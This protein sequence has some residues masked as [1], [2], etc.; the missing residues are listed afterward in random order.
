[1]GAGCVCD[2][3]ISNY[4]LKSNDNVICL[5]NGHNYYQQKSNKRMSNKK[6]HVLYN[7]LESNK[8][9]KEIK[10]NSDFNNYEKKLFDKNLNLNYNLGNIISIN[11]GKNTSFNFVGLS[12][13]DYKFKYI[14]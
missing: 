11:E 13:E 10:R 14:F 3:S 8:D 1:M 7:I 9:T 4:L 5:E 2:N 6:S 12:R